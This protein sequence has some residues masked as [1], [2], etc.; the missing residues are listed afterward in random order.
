MRL[1]NLNIGEI[2][3]YNQS[4]PR[5]VHHEGLAHRVLATLGL[6][7]ARIRQRAELAALDEFVRQDIGITEADVWRETRKAPWEA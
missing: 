5:G 4:L 1:E 7:R 6:W 2:G 3:F